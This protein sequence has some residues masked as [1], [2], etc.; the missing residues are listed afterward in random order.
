MR[1]SRSST[2]VGDILV[3]H[4]VITLAQKH[5]AVCKQHGSG[6]MIGEVMQDLG[7]I[8]ISQLNAALADQQWRR[9]QRRH[10]GESETA[11]DRR[12]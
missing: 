12:S 3:E 5:E 11:L 1:K 2:L 4:G 9:Q 7:F 6:R 8:T 10:S